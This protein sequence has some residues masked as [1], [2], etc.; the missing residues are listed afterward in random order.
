MRKAFFEGP[1]MPSE[2]ILSTAGLNQ[3]KEVVQAFLKNLQRETK[4]KL[5]AVDPRSI[6]AYEYRFL[7]EELQKDIYKFDTHFNAVII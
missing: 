5:D 7:L 4:K 6:K 1:I 2:W 3:D